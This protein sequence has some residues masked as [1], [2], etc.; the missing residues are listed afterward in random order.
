[1][2]HHALPS[3]FGLDLYSRGV[4]FASRAGHLLSRLKFF[5]DI[6][7]YLNENAGMVPRLLYYD[8][9]PNLF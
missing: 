3:G 2:E 1:M 9:L 4:R 6:P 7:Q 5:L 8:F